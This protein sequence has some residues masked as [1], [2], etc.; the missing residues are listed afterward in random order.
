MGW[1]GVVQSSSV[2]TGLEDGSIGGGSS[3]HRDGS[4]QVPGGESG[5]DRLRLSP[6]LYLGLGRARRGISGVT[7]WPAGREGAV[8][9]HWWCSS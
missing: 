3:G 6:R 7:P 8:A 4:D 9:G 1:R 2:E 5:E